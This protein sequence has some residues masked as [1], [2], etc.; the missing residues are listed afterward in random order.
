MDAGVVLTIISII[1]G[2]ATTVY[3]AFLL[4]KISIINVAKR[5]MNEWRDNDDFEAV[6][7]SISILK[8]AKESIDIFDDGDYFPNSTYN[9]AEFIRAI[10]EKLVEN[11]SFKVRCLFNICDPRL[12]FVQEF[13]GDHRVDIYQRIDGQRPKDYHYK[14]AD[15]GLK[16]AISEHSLSDRKRRYRDFS[17]EGVSRSDL[18]KVK[19]F[20]LGKT[21]QD[22]ILFKKIEKRAM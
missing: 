3:I 10:K 6:N 16:G 2:V 9:S 7:H 5:N 4:R 18:P 15:G 17:F 12:R 14:I 21:K 22:M 13:A 19:E 1:Y 8:G 11:P 20:V